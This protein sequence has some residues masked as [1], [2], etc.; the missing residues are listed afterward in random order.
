MVRPQIVLG[1]VV[2][3]LL[4]LGGAAIGYVGPECLTLPLPAEPLKPSL[5]FESKGDYSGRL[6]RH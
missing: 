3:I 6:V 5:T 2:G 1:L 4:G